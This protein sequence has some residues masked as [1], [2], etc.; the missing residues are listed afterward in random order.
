MHWPLFHFYCCPRLYFIL[1]AIQIIYAPISSEA[2]SLLNQMIVLDSELLDSTLL[3]SDSHCGRLRTMA[4]SGL[5]DGSNT[6]LYRQHYCSAF[7]IRG[8]IIT[9]R[10]V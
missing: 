2:I 9:R 6:I 10:R 4:P 3:G 5:K 1:S 8:S 7:E